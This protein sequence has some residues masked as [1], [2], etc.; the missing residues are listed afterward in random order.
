MSIVVC[1]GEP[2]LKKLFRIGKYTPFE[3][4]DVLKFK[5]LPFFRNEKPRRV[6]QDIEE[7]FRLTDWRH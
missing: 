4:M 5:K 6:R 7:L 3:N 2:F 1:P